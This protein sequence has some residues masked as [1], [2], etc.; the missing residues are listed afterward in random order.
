MFI[1]IVFFK[2]ITSPIPFAFVRFCFLVIDEHG[3]VLAQCENLHKNAGF[4]SS[5]LP[6]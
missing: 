3:L 5:N 6:K 1:F 4:V 2:G